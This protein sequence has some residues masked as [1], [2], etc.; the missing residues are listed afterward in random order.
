MIFFIH[1][2]VVEK[3]FVLNELLGVPPKGYTFSNSDLRVNSNNLLYR[4]YKKK[5]GP[6]KFKLSIAY[7]IVLL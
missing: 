6:F 1:P 4:V 7:L 2:Q 5:V 3:I